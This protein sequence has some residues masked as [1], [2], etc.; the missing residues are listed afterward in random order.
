MPTIKRFEDLH[1]WSRSRALCSELYDVSARGIFTRDY[2]LKDQTR[3]AAVSIPLNIAE[4]FSRKSR[5][6]FQRALFT[7]HGSVAEVQT[8]LYLALDL[9]Y[10]DETVFEQLYRES[11]EISRMIS[12]LIKYLNT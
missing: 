11:E 9:R 8:C 3:R 10:I 12:G 2:T 6:E 5:R 7:A 1:V 4:G